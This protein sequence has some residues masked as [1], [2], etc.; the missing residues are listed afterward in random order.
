[1]Y[2]LIKM[3]KKNYVSTKHLGD[4]LLN[5]LNDFVYMLKKLFSAAC[6]FSLK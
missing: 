1:M 5:V 3:S 4:L 6:L 2:H